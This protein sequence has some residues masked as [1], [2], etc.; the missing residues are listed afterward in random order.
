MISGAALVD[1]RAPVNPAQSPDRAPQAQQR[2]SFSDR[3]PDPERRKPGLFSRSDADAADDGS[4]VPT[5][6]ESSSSGGFLGFGKKKAPAPT[7]GIDAS[8]FPGGSASMSQSP[9]SRGGRFSGGATVANAGDNFATESSSDGS[10]DLPGRTVEKERSGFSL[11]KPSL[12]VPSL[13]SVPSLARTGSSGGGGMTSAGTYVV[14]STAQFM[15]YGADQMQSEIRAL[16]AGTT[17]MVTKPGEQ[18]SGIQL[19]DGTQGIV[20]N[21][22]LRPTSQ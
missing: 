17:V 13:P 22:N 3:M 18:W 7:P 2:V 8:L 21:K 19:S 10:F 15:V 1:G 5:S 6:R 9:P 14:S 11:P 4:L 16:P 20:Q 12:S